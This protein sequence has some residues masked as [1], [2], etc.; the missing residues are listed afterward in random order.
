VAAS[1]S[2]K[3]RAEEPSRALRLRC[4]GVFLLLAFTGNGYY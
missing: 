4:T 2:V 3:E 1:A